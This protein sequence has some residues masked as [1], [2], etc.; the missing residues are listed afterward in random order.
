MRIEWQFRVRPRRALKIIKG[1]L[2]LSL[3][4]VGARRLH[5]RAYSLTG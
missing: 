2:S 3:A 1:S 4:E 5:E